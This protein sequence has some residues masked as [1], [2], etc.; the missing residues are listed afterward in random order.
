MNNELRIYSWIPSDYRTYASVEFTPES[1]KWY[2]MKMR[3]DPAGSKAIVRGKLWPRGEAEPQSWTIEMEDS[4]PNLF[5][6]PGLFGKAEV[7]EISIDNIKVY[8]NK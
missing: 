1:H 5:G 8:P 2:T 4:A 3:V 7:A 6:S